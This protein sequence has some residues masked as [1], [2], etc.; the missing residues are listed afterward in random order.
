MGRHVPLGILLEIQSHHAAIQGRGARQMEEFGLRLPE[1]EPL[2]EI[3]RG[4]I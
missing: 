2:L 3:D 1:L 4:P